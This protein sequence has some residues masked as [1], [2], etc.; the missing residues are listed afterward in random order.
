MRSGGLSSTQDAG[1]R[2]WLLEAPSLIVLAVVVVPSWRWRQWGQASVA[3]GM[4]LTRLVT[5]GAVAR[6]ALP[7]VLARLIVPA[8][9][10]VMV[11]PAA[12]TT[13]SST[14]VAMVFALGPAANAP[15]ADRPELLAFVGI[16]AVDVMEDAV[17]V[18]FPGG[19]AVATATLHL[20]LRGQH[21][22][23]FALYLL[24]F[25]LLVFRICLRELQ[26][27]EATFLCPCTP[28]RQV[29]HL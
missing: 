8:L 4:V 29:E 13:A 16:V 21:G 26:E 11:V 17:R 18:A 6:W 9:A 24:S 22:R 25:G 14:A 15:V 7:A 19:L 28:G 2:A 1:N 23:T 20:W 5:P 3:L 12:S 10:G 27:G